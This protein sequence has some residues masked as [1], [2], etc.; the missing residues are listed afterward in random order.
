MHGKGG[1]GV[2]IVSCCFLVARAMLHG[3]DDAFQL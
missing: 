2:F 1:G 3:D